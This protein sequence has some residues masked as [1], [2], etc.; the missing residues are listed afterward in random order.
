MS[1][2]T[3][4]SWVRNAA[5]STGFVVSLALLTVQAAGPRFFPDDPLA[6]DDD[7][8]FD[9]SGAAPRE[10]SETY[11]FVIEPVR[12]S[13]VT[14][15]RSAAVNV[16]TLDEVP[17]SSWFTNRIGRRPMTAAEIARGPD[18]LDRIEIDEWIVTAGKGPAGFQP[19]FRAVNAL[20]TRP[21]GE[22]TLYQLELDTENLSR[23]G[24][25]RRD[26]RHRDLPRD[27]LQRGRHV[28]GE[29]RSAGRSASRPK[30]RCA[31]RPACG[32]STPRTSRKSSRPVPAIPTAPTG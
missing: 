10:L 20:D 8:A 4:R 14:G 6:T 17:D 31:T 29:R 21:I 16:N 32:P 7:A 27:R 11:D 5:A 15:G 28:S 3:A 22:R 23:S 30:P 13:R 9:A 25:Q 2:E 24:D 19:G 1:S 12:L 26:H 18:T